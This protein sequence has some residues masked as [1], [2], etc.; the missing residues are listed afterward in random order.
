MERSVGVGSIANKEGRRMKSGVDGESSVDTG[1]VG[2]GRQIHDDIS[3][4]PSSPNQ[5]DTTMN[6]QIP[7]LAV[8]E[9]ASMDNTSRASSA[10]KTDQADLLESARSEMGKVKEENEILK[11]TLA[12]IMKEYQSLQLHLTNMV[13]H[14]EAKKSTDV[15]PTNQEMEE[16]EISLSLGRNS[17]EPKKDEKSSNFS[18]DKEDEQLKEGLALRLDCKFERSSNLGS[19][20]ITPNLSPETSFEEPKEEE[21]GETWTPSKILKTTRSGEDEASQ[22]NNVKKARVSVRARCDTP[23][24]NDGCQW[25]KYGQKIAKGNPCPRAYYR[26]TVAPACPVRKQVQRCAEDMS[27]LITTYEGS[28]NHP[29]PIS[30]TAMASTTSAAAS[31]LMSGSSN[32]G[33]ALGSS[34][35]NTT[36]ADLHGLNFNFSDNTRSR[37]QFYLPNSS[38]SSTPSYPTITLDLTAPPPSS[39]SSSSSS[40][41]NR[42]NSSFHTTAPRYS[43]SFNFSSTESNSLPTSWSN[44]YLSYGTQPYNRSQIGSLTLGRQPQ[45]HFYQPYMQKNNPTPPQ[46]QQALS[47]TI[48]AATKAITSDPSFRSVLE[49]AISSIVNKGSNGGENFSQNLSTANGNGCSTYLSSRSSSS[50][51]QQGKLMF[52]PPPLPYSTTSSKSPSSSPTD[53]RDHIT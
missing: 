2:N 41:F 1:K 35:T 50:N 9:R 32:S 15:A 21:A 13:Q 52:L 12:K 17:S 8:I 20:E 42:L 5:K 18:K 23:T 11:M 27:I 43:T 31:M 7:T 4:K 30:A 26:C 53:K 10:I 37:P 16:P 19:N 33:S 28:H 14:E 40:Q 22:L 6:K 29:L 24:M 47:E 48:V 49:A 39:S 34:S 38:I 51:A 44:G 36:S 46:P 3:S 25:R 45:E